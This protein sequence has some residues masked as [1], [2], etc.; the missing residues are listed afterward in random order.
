MFFLRSRASLLK[1]LAGVDVKFV[2]TTDPKGINVT[3]SGTGLTIANRILATGYDYHVHVKPVTDG[4]CTSTGG[5]LDPA[6]VGVAKP[7]DPNNLTT[8]QTG[9]LAGKHGNF[10]GTEDGVV[11]FT[12]Y[13]DTQL[14][15]SGDANN[16]LV[17][18]SVVIHNNGTRIACADIITADATTTTSGAAKLV[19]SLALSG[20]VAFMMLAF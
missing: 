8:C 4:N 17:G 3:I 1:L 18:R 9:D 14:S 10:M 6:N 15:F 19:G 20:V 16:T 5:H 13:I 7:C 12:T 11:P 2:F